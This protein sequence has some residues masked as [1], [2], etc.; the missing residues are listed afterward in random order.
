MY[1]LKIVF[2]NK[3]IPQLIYKTKNIKN[4]EIGARVKVS[5]KNTFTTGIIINIYKQKKNNKNINYKIKYIYKLI[6]KYSLIPINLLKTIIIVSKYYFYPLGV[7][8]FNIIPKY[9]PTSLHIDNQP[10][11][12]FNYKKIYKKYYKYKYIY[13]KINKFL[14]R[15]IIW[16]FI[17]NK[18]IQH[19]KYTIYHFILHKLI[20]QHK[21]I[22]ILV[23]TI[24]NI[25]FIINNN[26]QQYQ[27][28]LDIWHSKLTN[29][30]KYITWINILKKKT[31]II[32]GT[33]TAVFLPFVQLSFIIIYNEHDQLYKEKKFL[34]NIKNIIF[35]RA[36]ILKIPVIL[37]SSTPNILSYYNLKIKKYKLIYIKNTNK[38]NFPKIQN[39]ILN[40]NYN[41]NY[42]IKLNN[43]IIT[44]INKHLLNKNNI[45]IIFNKT[46]YADK[47]WCIKCKK[48]ITCPICKNDYSFNHN[49]KIIVCNNCNYSIRKCYICKQNKILFL[50]K[51][52]DYI[53]IIIKKIF[54]DTHIINLNKKNLININLTKIKNSKN[55]IFISTN[56]INNINY[57]KNITL[58]IFLNIDY[59]LYSNNHI[60]LE[61]FTQTYYKII[62]KLNHTNKNKEIIIQT[63]Y[64]EHHIW[65]NLMTHQYKW[66]LKQYLKIRK[67]INLPP[68]IYEIYLYA[69]HKNIKKIH[70]FFRYILY[71]IFLYKNNN[72]K[73]IGPFNKNNN[74]IKNIFSWY[75]TIYHQ[76]EYYLFKLMKY[77]I[78]KIK[79][80][81]ILWKIER[82]DNF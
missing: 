66:C 61:S 17:S 34:Y 65:H 60:I 62:E 41:P 38:H 2:K 63:Q 3:N 40:T 79:H 53:Y 35:I 14:N 43:Q 70:S 82:N 45:L 72:I 10:Y 52:I 21:Q 48:K 13:K 18:Y 31:L 22:L 73:I 64:P 49:K 51:G 71:I 29:K 6:D 59:L 55:K 39:S 20:K 46:G 68:Y 44:T 26:F 42:N 47:L 77:I 80:I 11:K 15:F 27:Q 57:I 58:I 4:I 74:Y 25:Q 23:P 30:K 56:I 28:Y 9:I 32:I 24:K 37:E 78:Q 54:S 19:Q 12:T 67:L 76:K 16:L 5:I 81:P 36:K 7:L 8:L 33:R 1:I 50:N 75:I 69:I